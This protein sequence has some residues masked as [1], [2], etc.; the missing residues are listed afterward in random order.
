MSNIIYTRIHIYIYTSKCFGGNCVVDFLCGFSC[1][2]FVFPVDFR[3]G[4]VWHVGGNVQL[5]SGSKNRISSAYSGVN[6]YG[7]MLAVNGVESHR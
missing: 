3:P 5:T 2:K 4:T 6:W 7:K 1:G